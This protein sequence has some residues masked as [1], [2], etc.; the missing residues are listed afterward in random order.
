MKKIFIS[1]SSIDKEIVD[2]FIDKILRLGL[3]IDTKD[4]ACTSRED[5]GVKTGND[6]RNYIKENISNCDFVFFMISE[7]YQNSQICLNEMG[8]AWA[9]DRLVMP[10]V[11]PNVSFENIGWLYNVRKG[12]KLNDSSALDSLFEDICDKYDCRLKVSTWNMQKDAFIKYID[13]S[14]ENRSQNLP[15]LIADNNIEGNEPDLLDYREK[16]DYYILL[17]RNSLETITSALNNATESTNKTTKILTNINNNKNASPSQIRPVLLKLAKENN[18]LSE[19]CTLESTKLKDSFDEAI[20]CAIKIKELAEFCEDDIEEER[21]AIQSMIESMEGF[22]EAVV[23]AKNVFEG[24]NTNLDKTFSASKK[25]VVKSFT[26][27]IDN[28]NF[29]ITRANE[30]LIYI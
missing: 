5:T 26:G 23:E 8:A 16:F 20:G 30:L 25:K 6:I 19:T 15:A 2:V 24:D 29:N 27:L 21:Q 28:L 1:H 10:L 4:I 18:T 22:M 9:T 7:N 3:N 13:N 12:M 17:F 14:F 11:F